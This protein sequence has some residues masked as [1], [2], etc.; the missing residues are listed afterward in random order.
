MSLQYGGSGKSDLDISNLQVMRDHAENNQVCPNTY[1][2]EKISKQVKY[3]PF[4]KEKRRNL[5]LKT[6]TDSVVGPG[7]YRDSTKMLS[8]SLKKS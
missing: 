2:P 6:G 5:D 8:D 3:I 7:S 4:S 1:Y